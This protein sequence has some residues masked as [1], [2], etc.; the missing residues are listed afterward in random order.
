MA[1][2]D[3][4]AKTRMCMAPEDIHAKAYKTKMRSSDRDCAKCLERWAHH[5]VR[6]VGVTCL[7]VLDEHQGLS[8]AACAAYNH[9]GGICIAVVQVAIAIVA[10]FIAAWDIPPMNR[11]VARWPF[12]NFVLRAADEAAVGAH[13][14]RGFA[15]LAVLA[16]AT[17]MAQANPCVRHGSDKRCWTNYQKD[18]NACSRK[19][20]ANDYHAELQPHGATVSTWD[21]NGFIV[22]PTN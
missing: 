19:G 2:E 11:F 4:N 14:F 1:P 21:H 20:D 13:V 16:E 8:L 18:L 17:P 9:I 15:S 12:H 6:A 3:I 10:R 7:E 22:D 5:P